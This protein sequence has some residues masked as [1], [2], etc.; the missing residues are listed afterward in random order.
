MNGFLKWGD[1]A[2]LLPTLRLKKGPGN[3]WEGCGLHL[4]PGM[5]GACNFL[6]KIP[7]ALLKQLFQ[8]IF[9]WF[10]GAIIIGDSLPS[11]LIIINTNLRAKKATDYIYY[12]ES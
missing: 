6:S 9:F 8:Y 5:L 12:R 1:P 11:Q 10:L 3:E 2:D 4:A 7:I